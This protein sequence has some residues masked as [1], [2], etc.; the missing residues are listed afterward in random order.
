M[1]LR[2]LSRKEE[3]RLRAEKREKKLLKDQRMKKQEN[4]DK[5]N[6]YNQHLQD[7]KERR[8]RQIAEE[9]A[10]V[11]DKVTN[12]KK[13]YRTLHQSPPV[14]NDDV[15]ESYQISD[16]QQSASS[17]SAFE[18][19]AAKKKKGNRPKSAMPR[20]RYEEALVI[21]EQKHAKFI[22]EQ[23]RN[24]ENVRQ[25]VAQSSMQVEKAYQKLET[26]CN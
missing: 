5:W 18:D 22:D 2:Q 23:Q 16:H 21:N 24:L 19:G 20:V 25:K 13:Y 3:I 26:K 11:V 9:K 7:V 14:K 4:Q 8:E 15:E 1:E 6:S 17:D 10:L 12:P